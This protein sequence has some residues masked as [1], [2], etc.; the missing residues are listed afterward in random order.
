MTVKVNRQDACSTL[1]DLSEQDQAHDVQR[2]RLGFDGVGMSGLTTDRRGSAYGCVTEPGRR[3]NRHV[4]PRLC[5]NE[6]LGG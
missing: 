4:S 1:F 6:N 5:A 2:C 3:N